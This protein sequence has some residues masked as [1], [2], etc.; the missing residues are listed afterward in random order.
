MTERISTT[1]SKAKWLLIRE[2]LKNKEKPDEYWKDAIK[3]IH[4]RI[5]DR[6]LN[7]LQILIEHDKSYEGAGFS[8]ATIEC[9][10]LEFIASLTEGKIFLKDKPKGA[11][12]YYYDDSAKL[13]NRFLRNSNIFKPYF[14]S[15]VGQPKYRPD[16]FYKNVRCALIHEAQTK[17]NWEIRIFGKV[18]SND[19]KNK[20]II[21]TDKKG[22]KVLYR[23]A[24][25]FTLKDFFDTY[26]HEKLNENNTRARTLRK[27]LARKIDYILEIP[28]D[29]KYWWELKNI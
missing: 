28:P 14:S 26:C 4:E 21:E 16:D 11:K 6:Y 5:T 27:Y 3:L 29:N 1:Y 20:I 13:Y 19:F 8:I 24:L 10:L 22:K 2:Q 7:P 17:E 25:Y 23:T 15:I 9:S 12:D 18:K